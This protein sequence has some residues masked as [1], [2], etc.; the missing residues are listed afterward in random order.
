MRA[1][2]RQLIELRVD[3]QAAADVGTVGNPPWNWHRAYR[4]HVRCWDRL[5]DSGIRGA[6]AGV[7]AYPCTD[8]PRVSGHLPV[9]CGRVYFMRVHGGGDS[10]RALYQGSLEQ[11]PLP[12]TLLETLPA[13]TTA[14]ELRGAVR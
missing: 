9:W 5:G 4:W 3:L 11:N 1:K 2:F 6:A 12:A 10:T 14:K 8:V 7:L 13:T